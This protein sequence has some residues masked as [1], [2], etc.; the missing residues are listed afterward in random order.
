MMNRFLLVLLVGI[1]F[2]H[3]IRDNALLF[4]LNKNEPLLELDVNG[5]LN[6]GYHDEI[7]NFLS[8]RS[9]SYIIEPLLL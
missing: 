8:S 4:C 9:N 1:I 6:R 3:E 7:H 2:S 5:K